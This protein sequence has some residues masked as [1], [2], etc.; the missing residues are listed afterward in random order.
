MQ[1][2]PRIRVWSDRIPRVL[3]F[4]CCRGLSGNK[5]KR[6]TCRDYIEISTHLAIFYH[7]EDSRSHGRKQRPKGARPRA[8]ALRT[9]AP[10]PCWTPFGT[11]F[12]HDVPPTYWIKNN[13]IPPHLPTQKC[14]EEEDYI[15]RP[16]WPLEEK[17]RSYHRDWGLPLKENLFSN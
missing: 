10:A 3:L 6:T 1:P 15:R 12:A 9:W 8:P 14:I 4:I 13:I 7:L 11:L 16:P 17:R 2:T 5:E